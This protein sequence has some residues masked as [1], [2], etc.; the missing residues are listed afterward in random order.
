MKFQAELRG[1]QFRPAECKEHLKSLADQEDVVLE[2][3]RDPNNE[4]DEFAIKLIH[5]GHFLG[6]VQ[7]DVA[8]E[9]APLMDEGQTF[10]A[11]IHSWLST[12]KPYVVIESV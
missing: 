12:I 11:T 8:E 9:I 4:Y 10:T 3:E 5:E 1:A 2:L 6:F 7:K